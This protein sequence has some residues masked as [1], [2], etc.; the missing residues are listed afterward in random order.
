MLGLP[1]A[2]SLTGRCARPSLSSAPS[3][4][5]RRKAEIRRLAP[6][7]GIQIQCSAE[8]EELAPQIVGAARVSRLEVLLVAE[9]GPWLYLP[10][11]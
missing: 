4:Q 6:I 7:I 10:A 5:S 2:A 3:P 1:L 11:I 8:D 9:R